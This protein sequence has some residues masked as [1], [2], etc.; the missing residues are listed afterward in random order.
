MITKEHLPHIHNEHN[1]LINPNII[2]TIG[3]DRLQHNLN[4]NYNSI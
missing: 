1:E 3:Y 2:E 4:N